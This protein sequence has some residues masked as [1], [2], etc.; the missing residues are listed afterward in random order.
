MKE[1]RLSRGAKLAPMVVGHRA[2]R[3]GKKLV[4][5]GRGLAGAVMKKRRVK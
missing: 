4:D 2:V 3:L 1:G 5:K